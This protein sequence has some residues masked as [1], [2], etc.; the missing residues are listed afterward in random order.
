MNNA[1]S[2]TYCL[3][4]LIKQALTFLQMPSAYRMDLA[5]ILIDPKDMSSEIT[6]WKGASIMAGLDTAQEFWINSKEWTKFG[7]KILREK[8]SFPWT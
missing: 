4:D 5:D 6:S 2:K 1:F 7:Q 3:A 8:S